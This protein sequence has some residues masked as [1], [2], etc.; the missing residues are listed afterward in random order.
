MQKKSVEFEVIDT[1][2]PK[3][4]KEEII[5]ESAP[6]EKHRIWKI[7]VTI[8]IILL[9]LAILVVL[10]FT[11][12]DYIT[13][14]K[15][16][17]NVTVP[18][19]TS[20]NKTPVP[21]LNNTPTN[22]T[23]TTG[24]TTPPDEN[25]TPNCANKQCGG[26]GCDGSCGACNTTQSCNSTGRCVPIIN[27]T[28]Q[29]SGKQ[30]GSNGCNGTCAPGCSSGQSCNSTGGCQARTINLTDNIS[31]YGIT[32]TFDKEYEYGTF[33][34]GDY[35]VIGPVTV[36]NV[37]PAWNGITHGSMIDPDP[38]IIS[39]GYDTRA[40]NYQESVRV[41]F[42]AVISSNKSLISVR[43]LDTCKSGGAGEC[44][45]DAAVLTIVDK[46]MPSGTFRPAYINTTKKFY[47][48]SQVDYSLLPN[49]T[50]PG[51]LPNYSDV[52]KRVWLDHGPK[53]S[54]AVI[55]PKNNMQPYPRDSSVQVSVMSMLVM[56]NISEKQEFTNRLIQLGIDLYSISLK[57]GD[58]FRAYGGFGSGRKW[59]ILFAG[60]MLNDNDMK[61]PPEYVP[62]S[63][64]I[65]KFGEDGH[66]FY[67][68]P[69]STYPG[70]KPLFG[71]ICSYNNGNY[72][73]SSGDKDCRD[74]LGIGDGCE[75]RDCCTSFTWVGQA[76]AARLMNAKELWGWPAF[77]D[78]T[79][80][81]VL[82]EEN[83][84]SPHPYGND[85]IEYMWKTYCPSGGDC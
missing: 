9:I 42:P 45:S 11:V 69:T 80:R 79:D 43:G 44:L 52:M 48:V 5:V 53:V 19:N 68:Q 10:S 67:G 85:F 81:W 39:Q 22:L 63:S 12:Y 73:N 8:L 75:Y 34:N 25:C 84:T 3:I 26:D 33:V 35:W 51:N 24:N 74:P 71:Q 4:K 27:C 36:T 15:N 16:E 20:Q 7:L 46:P 2:K 72:C 70:G 49:F 32:W 47:T 76:L 54:G 38:S 23:N 66:T 77:F 58:A 13:T 1:L 40:Y 62:G 18:P 30:C 17:T 83:K 56:L 82:E 29:C 41:V 78:Y 37:N 59:P 21:V 65:K 50:S 60:I 55:H 61:N 14:P 6:V 64:S 57:N 28:P 31:Q